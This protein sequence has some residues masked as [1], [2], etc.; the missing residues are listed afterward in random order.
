VDAP[1]R[2]VGRDVNSAETSRGN[3]AAATWTFRGGGRDRG[4]S[5][6]A[7]ATWIVRRDDEEFLEEKQMFGA[8][9]ATL[10]IG[11]LG[12]QTGYALAARQ[13]DTGKKLGSAAKM[14]EKSTC[15]VSKRRHA[16]SFARSV[17]RRCS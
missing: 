14:V 11:E 3:A 9:A 5:A 2:R 8:A 7:A 4:H 15:A 16:F 17:E 12:E 13:D 1:W 10:P 6:E